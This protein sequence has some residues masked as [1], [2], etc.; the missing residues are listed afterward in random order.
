M[1]GQPTNMAGPLTETFR[2]LDDKDQ[3]TR[4]IAGRPA[5]AGWGSLGDTPDHQ[6]TRWVRHLEDDARQRAVASAG[7]AENGESS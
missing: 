6:R 7:A 5:E 3:D 4:Y 2:R 1:F